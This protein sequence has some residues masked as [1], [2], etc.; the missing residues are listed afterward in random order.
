MLFFFIFLIIYH[1]PSV[2]LSH[3]LSIFLNS[4]K[5]LSPSII[6]SQNLHGL[7]FSWSSLINHGHNHSH[8]HQPQPQPLTTKKKKKK[9]THS[10]NCSKNPP[11]TRHKTHHP[12]NPDPHLNPDPWSL[13]SI[14]NPRP[15]P[16]QPTVSTNPNHCRT[17]THRKAMGKREEESEGGE[18]RKK[19]KIK[20]KYTHNYCWNK[21]IVF[22]LR[23][24]LQWG[25]IKTISL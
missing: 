21:K 18:R 19:G 25:C 9:K 2:S 12:S 17:Q 14:F 23:F 7:S 15:Q 20:N 22:G 3:Y 4:V 5:L 16:T 10:T 6:C 24:V 13:I 8:H 11:Q 1:S